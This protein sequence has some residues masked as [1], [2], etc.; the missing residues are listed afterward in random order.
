[1]IVKPMTDPFAPSK[2]EPE[3]PAARCKM[4]CE[5]EITQDCT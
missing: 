3:R 2:T 5:A 1:M 4:S